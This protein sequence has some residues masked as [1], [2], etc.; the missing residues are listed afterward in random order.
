VAVKEQL[1]SGT[2]F[3]GRERIIGGIT[4]QTGREQKDN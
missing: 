2:L 4:Q 3:L 1:P